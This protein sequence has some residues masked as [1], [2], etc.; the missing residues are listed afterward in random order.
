MPP[1]EAPSHHSTAPQSRR[2]STSI[3]AGDD[4]D[5]LIATD[6]VPQVDR[7]DDD[8]AVMMF[9]SGTA[10]SPK[11]AMLSHGNLRANLEQAQAH[12]GRAQADDVSFGVLPLFHIFGLNVVL[13]LT[14]YTGA[15]IV[16]V[17]SLRPDGASSRSA[18]TA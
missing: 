2:S 9:T 18:T 13:G 14:L 11:A 4:L 1:L 6:P 16:L 12:A 7:D 15:R 10:G 17:R 5:E 3:D 8:L